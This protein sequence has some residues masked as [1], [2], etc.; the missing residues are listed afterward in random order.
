MMQW[1]VLIMYYVVAEL[2]V[3]PSLQQR[4]Q[5]DKQEGGGDDG[6]SGVGKCGLREGE[7]HGLTNLCGCVV[8][9]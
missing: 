3:L 5:A 6:G 1:G 8:F 4:W 2:I 7:R 9:Q